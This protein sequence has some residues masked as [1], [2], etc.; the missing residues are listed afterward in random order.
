MAVIWIVTDQ[1]SGR[2]WHRHEGA[3]GSFTWR[4]SWTHKWFSM[5]NSLLVMVYTLA[6]IL[7]VVKVFLSLRATPKA[8]YK[9]PEWSNIVLHFG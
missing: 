8:A 3:D 2:R 1:W 9:T 7:V 6:R 4:G 5:A